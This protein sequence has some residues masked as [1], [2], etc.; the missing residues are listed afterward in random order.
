MDGVHEVKNS[1]YAWSLFTSF[2]R[3]TLRLGQ[4]YVLARILGPEGYGV[5]AIAWVVLAIAMTLADPGLSTAYIQRWGVTPEQQSSL[6]WMNALLGAIVAI[7]LAMAA[8]PLAAFFDEQQYV[9]FVYLIATQV[10]LMGV[11]IPVRSMAE[12]RID[13]RSVSIVDSVAAVIGFASTITLAALGVG[14]ISVLFGTLAV[15]ASSCLGTWALLSRGWRPLWKFRWSD[16]S[17]FF[18]FTR[19]LFLINFLNSLY[20][21]ADVLVAG[22][23]MPSSE[24]G[25]YSLPRTM[26]AEVQLIVNPAIARVGV[27]AVSAVQHDRRAT[28]STFRV[29]LEIGSF[30]TAP[31]FVFVVVY[32][33][34]LVRLMLGEDWT[35]AQTALR[36]L[37]LW[38]YLRGAT[39]LSGSLV[40]GTGSFGRGLANV[41]LLA[42]VTIG[43]VLLTSPH[44][45]NFLAAGMAM[46]FVIC[47][48][49]HWKIVVNPLAGLC[50]GDY[51]SAICV[52]LALALAAGMPPLIMMACGP[53]GVFGLVTGGL[54]F[55]PLYVLL[56]IKFNRESMGVHTTLHALRW[57]ARRS[58]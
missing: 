9:L 43:L 29:M 41:T 5:L 44:G 20:S 16:V 42:A 17:S 51:L 8:K 49:P 27:P 1:S 48:V 38:A 46:A 36:L 12:K 52:P 26:T 45:T 11:T 18:G 37:A 21:N 22:R 32:A 34:L 58:D 50:L 56:S 39:S 25:L 2:V 3:T 10:I 13:F 30:L 28:L 15:T 54:T 55:A 31:L 57:L 33:D 7:T 19:R 24:V 14:P 35:G 47:L 40:I 23:L 53:V 6:F 4:L